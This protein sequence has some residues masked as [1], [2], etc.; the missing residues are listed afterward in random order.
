VTA[1]TEAPNRGPYGAQLEPNYLNCRVPPRAR[2][3]RGTHRARHR[4]MRPRGES[5]GDPSVAISRRRACDR[6]PVS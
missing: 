6:E 1:L 2:R 5:D 3:E 4:R